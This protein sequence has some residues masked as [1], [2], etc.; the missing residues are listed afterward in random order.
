MSSLAPIALFA[1]RRPRHLRTTLDALLANPEAA[2]SDLWIFSDAA[3]EPAAQFDVMEVRALA[4]QVGGFKSVRVIERSENFGLARSIVDGVTSLCAQH[5]RVIVV[6]DDLTVSPGFL[7]FL[8]RALERYADEERVMQISGYQFPGHFEAKQAAFLPLISCW[9]WATWTRAWRHYD[10]SAAGVERLR[11][12]PGLRRRFD[13]DGI[14][15]YSGM[16]ESQLAG[17]LDSWGVRWLLSVFLRDGM[18]L[19]PPVSLV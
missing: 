12:D 6:E 2:H 7:A 17:K 19:Y 9:G 18:V 1:Y 8:N 5:G 14:Y 3:R 4:A 13:L 11:A 10:P 16:L 15:D